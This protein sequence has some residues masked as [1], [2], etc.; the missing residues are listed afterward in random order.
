MAAWLELLQAKISEVG[1]TELKLKALNA[2]AEETVAPA[3]DAEPDEANQ[4]LEALKEQ[5]GVL[6]T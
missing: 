1:D 4:K 3:V 5:L 2:E 6:K